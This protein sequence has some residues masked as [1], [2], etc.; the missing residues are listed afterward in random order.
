LVGQHL[1]EVSVLDSYLQ[2][3]L[4]SLP[5]CTSWWL[6]WKSAAGN[7]CYVLANDED[8]AGDDLSLCEK[9]VNTNPFSWTR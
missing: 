4:T 7:Q 3:V 8:R 5:L 6:A 2:P 1:R 9:L